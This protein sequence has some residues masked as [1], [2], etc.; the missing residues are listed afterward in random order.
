MIFYSL[1]AKVQEPGDLG[2]AAFPATATYVYRDVEMANNC[3]GLN[4]WNLYLNEKGYIKSARTG[5]PGTIAANIPP[6]KFAKMFT[7][8]NRRFLRSMR[9]RICLCGNQ[10]LLPGKKWVI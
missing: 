5:S 1:V 6:E 3:S 10:G 4:D 8:Y 2:W 9:T 7:V